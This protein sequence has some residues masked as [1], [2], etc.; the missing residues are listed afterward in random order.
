M[1]SGRFILNS[2]F[3]T[4]RI[5]GEYEL[6][7]TIPNSYTT[8]AH[9]P[10]YTITLGTVE[11]GDNGDSFFIYYTSSIFNYATIGPIVNPK[12]SGATGLNGI[13]VYIVKNGNRYTMYLK[14]GNQQNA[15]TYKGFGMVITAHIKT[16]KDPF[17]E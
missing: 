16:F 6:S 1:K 17:S 15:E 2:D 11:L 13:A 5:T 8:P 4:T 12:P 10:N 7:G 14:F 9:S 3:C